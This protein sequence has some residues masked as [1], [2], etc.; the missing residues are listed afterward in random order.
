MSKT[1]PTQHFRSS[2]CAQTT[3][4]TSK[5]GVHEEVDP[6]FFT[7]EA[8]AEL[9]AL[10]VIFESHFTS[11][12][13]GC[14]LEIVPHPADPE[15]NYS[16]V[17]LRLSL[18]GNYPGIIP[19]IQVVQVRGLSKKH[20]E[21]LEN[22]LK[23]EAETYRGEEMAFRL[24]E[25]A[26]DF[27]LQH[28][29]VRLRFPEFSSWPQA[30]PSLH[31]E[32]RNRVEAE[33]AK[34]T[35]TPPTEVPSPSIQANMEQWTATARAM[36]TYD[37]VSFAVPSPRLPS[38]VPLASAVS[39]LSSTPAGHRPGPHPSSLAATELFTAPPRS[40]TPADSGRPEYR[41]PFDTRRAALLTHLLWIHCRRTAGNFTEMI[42]DLVGM[43]V[44]EPDSL[45][46][47]LASRRALPTAEGPA[48]VMYPRPLK[49]QITTLFRSHGPLHPSV[50]ELLD[51]PV[52]LAPYYVSNFEELEFLGR[53]AFG[54]V[55]RLSS[56]SLEERERIL[57][58]VRTLSILQHENVVRY[59]QAWIESSS[60]DIHTLADEASDQSGD[61]RTGGK[62]KRPPKASK[63]KPGAGRR[64]KKHAPSAEHNPF[65]LLQSSIGEPSR[66]LSE[67]PPVSTAGP[68]AARPPSPPLAPA[69]PT[70]PSIPE[71][72]PETS[73]WSPDRSPEWQTYTTRRGTKFR[74]PLPPSPPAASM[75]CSKAAGPLP[76]PSQPLGLAANIPTAA[77][78]RPCQK[79]GTD[80]EPD[81][82]EGGDDEEE[83]EEDEREDEEEEE[84][85][86]EEEDGIHSD[87]E[88]SS[89]GSSRSLSRFEDSD[90][91]SLVVF[92]RAPEPPLAVSPAKVM[93][94]SP[95]SSASDS[96]PD[97]PE[98]SDAPTA[99]HQPHRDEDSP[100]PQ[101]PMLLFIQMEFCPRQSLAQVASHLHATLLPGHPDPADQMIRN[102]ELTDEKQIWVIFQQILEGLAHIHSQGIIHRDLKPQ[103]IFVAR[104]GDVKQE[105]I[106]PIGDNHA[107]LFYL[108]WF[109][110]L[111]L[112]SRNDTT[113]TTPPNPT[114]PSHPFTPHDAALLLCSTIPGQIGDFGLSTL[115]STRQRAPDSVKIA[116]KRADLP[117]GPER[118]SKVGTFFYR[119]PELD[120]NA[121]DEKVDMFSLGIILFECWYHPFETQSERSRV[122]MALRRD[123]T[124]PEEFTRLHMTRQCELIRWLLDPDPAK[125][126]TA[127]QL[128]RDQRMPLQVQDDAMLMALR[129][130][131]DPHTPYHRELMQMLFV[132][133]EDVLGP[134]P[135]VSRVPHPSSDSSA[136][137]SLSALI[138]TA[139]A[140]CR[141]H[142][143]TFLPA[144][145]L[146][147][148]SS[149]TALTLMDERGAL[150]VIRTNLTAAFAAHVAATNTQWIRRYDVGPVWRAG[151]PDEVGHEDSG[152]PVEDHLCSFDIVEGMDP[153]PSGIP[154]PVRNVE[155]LLVALDLATRGGCTAKNLCIRIG[156]A[157]FVAAILAK[158]GIA[159]QQA[160][161]ILECLKHPW[162]DAQKLLVQQFHL[163]EA[164][165]AQLRHMSEL[166]GPARGSLAKLAQLETFA[167]AAEASREIEEMLGWAVRM[168]LSEELFLVDPTLHGRVP[169]LR[170]VCFEICLRGP[171]STSP[172]FEIG[173]GGRYCASTARPIPCV[174][175]QVALDRVVAAV[176]I[177]HPT[178]L[179]HVTSAG[180]EKALPEIIS[181]TS[182]LWQEG[183][184]ASYALAKPAEKADILQRCLHQG[185]AIVIIVR[186]ST[187]S[188]FAFKIHNLL[189]SRRHGREGGITDP[190]EYDLQRQEVVHHVKLLLGGS[191]ETPSVPQGKPWKVPG[192]SPARDPPLPPDVLE[193]DRV[194]GLPGN[195]RATRGALAVHISATDEA[196]ETKNMASKP[197]PVALGKHFGNLL[198]STRDSMICFEDSKQATPRGHMGHILRRS[199]YSHYFMAQDFI[200]D[201]LKLGI[202]NR[203]LSGL[204]WIKVD[205]GVLTGCLPNDL[206]IVLVF[207]SP[208][209]A[210][211]SPAPWPM[212]SPVPW[213]ARSPV[214][215]PQ[216]YQYNAPIEFEE[217][218]EHE[219]KAVQITKK[220]SEM[221][222]HLASEYM[223]AF[224]NT[225]GG[226][227]YFGV[228]D[229]GIIKGIRVDRKMRDT[230]RLGIDSAVNLYRPQV[231]PSLY[232]VTFV[233]VVGGPFEDLAVLQISVQK[234]RSPVYFTKPDRFSAYLRRDGGNIRMSPEVIEQRIKFGNTTPEIDPLLGIPSL[235][236][237]LSPMPLGEA[238]GSCGPSPMGP[239]PPP[240][241]AISPSGASPFS[242]SSEQAP[243]SA[244]SRPPS[245]MRTASIP[246]PT[247][248]NL[249]GGTGISRMDGHSPLDPSPLFGVSPTQSARI[250]PPALPRAFIGRERELEQI[251]RFVTEST[252]PCKVISLFGMPCCGKSALAHRLVR[253]LTVQGWD[254][255]LFQDLKGIL[256]KKV[257]PLE[258]MQA[259]ILS[260][261]PSVQL[262]DNPSLV[263]GLYQGI[264]QAKRTV[265]LL[266][267]CSTQEQVAELLPL[268]SECI[269]LVTSRRHLALTL[270]VETLEMRLGPLDSQDA[271]ELLMTLAPSADPASIPALVEALGYLPNAI[272]QAA[273]ITVLRRLT[274]ALLLSKLTDEHPPVELL[275]ELVMP[276]YGPAD[277]NEAH[278]VALSVFGGSFSIA[279]AAHV[280]QLAPDETV[281]A[282]GE[283]V[284]SSLLQYDETL[285][286]YV[287]NDLLRLYTRRANEE[288]LTEPELRLCEFC[289]DRIHELTA[290]R[291]ERRLDELLQDTHNFCR[292]F[293]ILRGFGYSPQPP[294][295]GP[296]LLF[297]L[298]RINTDL[299]G[300]GLIA[301]FPV[302]LMRE[303]EQL[304][305]LL[306]T[307]IPSK[308]A[309]GA[310]LLT[311]D[312]DL[313]S[314]P[315]PLAET[316]RAPK[317]KHGTAY[318]QVKVSPTDEAGDGPTRGSDETQTPRPPPAFS[319]PEAPPP[320]ETTPTAASEDPTDPPISVHPA[321]L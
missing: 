71:L 134:E 297:L 198:D 177:V 42:K 22:S 290:V 164:R 223:N 101:L 174:G 319:T 91:D 192:R 32:M 183:I 241:I 194:D 305:V 114:P 306:G 190:P 89:S 212:R 121:Y 254:H 102:H 294:Q 100:A 58:E 262:P 111:F 246:I 142:A 315:L 313:T 77:S 286:R 209:S 224:L 292:C 40:M 245:P 187:G 250:P 16:C 180:F 242:A 62:E 20:C 282:L 84:E 64:P 248:S 185:F 50:G 301:N 131:T 87:G 79:K 13:T 291:M 46:S 171:L 157:A 155:C 179:V 59:H 83:E 160:W 318:F 293:R 222:V 316:R 6:V 130:A 10:Q 124:F 295:S 243:G 56:R 189:P 127:R 280:L 27:L 298:T 86:E 81:E 273:R 229:N 57:R 76:T 44:F 165:A 95:E 138:T 122:L 178:P 225:R 308:K 296:A 123:L 182:Q 204:I 309:T 167:G 265:L 30:I 61:D 154:P 17:K 237:P 307:R 72:A 24:A 99:V 19:A 156:H 148:K 302:E 196:L 139:H 285:K 217:N 175:V 158:S 251:M 271:A 218:R 257:E 35:P 129:S 37:D 232:T 96:S 1:E 68:A 51:S 279:A 29:E 311:P 252:E 239:P 93:P 31:D 162:K 60:R 247:I 264:F 2:G 203:A 21:E 105:Q 287:C 92:A 63:R 82:E 210:I 9:E 26:K 74:E 11:S 53:G 200:V 310:G 221:V 236:P 256:T 8:Q 312:S 94:R 235:V 97:L 193:E 106:I 228:E 43:G 117:S 7:S 208:T 152:R 45:A 206:K 288:K 109:F 299:Q 90:S 269:V 216:A 172:T 107:H 128:L 54:E 115:A 283:L 49:E 75:P 120:Q 261:M 88:S 274:P 276:E 268:F 231:D 119:A 12:P 202:R 67:L 140:V 135:P 227:I 133:S 184:S 108:S 150:N 104:S 277:Y 147:P 258:A 169:F 240:A 317:K 146:E 303:W 18:N 266:E 289:A 321:L 300:S 113:I 253:D 320:T 73:A 110:L 238:P 275:R 214:P 284:E 47:I 65:Q 116:S 304:D 137:R 207:L 80:E 263:K 3:H 36:K 118:T 176:Q 159:Q 215:T 25:S 125:R 166:A 14:D 39:Q 69:I 211:R 15:K 52:T 244:R 314:A 170:G 153:D 272:T 195:G 249:R 188:G 186:P 201:A 163:S 168:G 197:S 112:L 233:P 267:N 205:R 136:S 34:A 260:A 28:N 149:A 144:G 220:L 33:Q 219:F 70:A 5:D 55:V 281:F 126:P 213:P 278:F 161:S 173:F 181:I 143:A 270:T 85:E 234:G 226:T 141:A 230:L 98:D 78:V 145:L 66:G 191:A 255:T 48:D 199:S 151:L 103:N 4:K 132:K 23:R 38:A 259:M 41:S